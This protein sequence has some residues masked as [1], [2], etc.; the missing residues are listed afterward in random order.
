MLCFFL[1]SEHMQ[2]HRHPLESIGQSG[3]CDSTLG[4]IDRYNSEKASLDG[5]GKAWD[6]Y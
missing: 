3:I 5:F 2:P 1:H 4:H 6:N